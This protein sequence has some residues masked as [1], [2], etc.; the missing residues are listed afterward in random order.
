LQEETTDMY[1]FRY[2][3][4]QPI[5]YEND[6]VS[7]V[8][9]PWSETDAEVWISIFDE[10]HSMR[11]GFSD[12]VLGQVRFQL[13]ELVGSKDVEAMGGEQP[14]VVMAKDIQL[15]VGKGKLPRKLEERFIAEKKLGT[16]TF[17]LQ[18]E[19]RER[20]QWANA[21]EEMQD[22]ELSEALNKML[23]RE[24]DQPK[25]FWGKLR[26]AKVRS[27]RSSNSH[28][29]RPHLVQHRTTLPTCN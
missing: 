3:L 12:D 28:M 23:N 26:E 24:D 19:L 21:K 4:L 29:W 17:A 9:V 10:D 6:R 25:G 8:L 16:I 22:I 1:A 7:G 18:L 2:P 20:K 5:R 13:K 27:S 14:L 15:P 11:D